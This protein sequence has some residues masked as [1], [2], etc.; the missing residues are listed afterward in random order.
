MSITNNNEDTHGGNYCESKKIKSRCRLVFDVSEEAIHSNVCRVK[1]FIVFICYY[2][3]DD[4]WQRNV[5]R[6]PSRIN[7]KK[8]DAK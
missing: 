2:Y 8:N 3:Y 4:E 6:S 7:D 5:I 1:H